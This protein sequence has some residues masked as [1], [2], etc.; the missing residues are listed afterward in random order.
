MYSLLPT[1][2]LWQWLLKIIPLR[3]A[4]KSGLKVIQ[5]CFMATE[6]TMWWNQTGGRCFP[7][8]SVNLR[9]YPR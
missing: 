7:I 4:Q 3:K 9:V 2:L 1:E 6:L 8:H 5:I